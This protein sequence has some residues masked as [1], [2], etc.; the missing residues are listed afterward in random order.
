MTYSGDGPSVTD[1]K[2]RFLLFLGGA[3][4]CSWFTSRR[5]RRVRDARSAVDDLRPDATV[6][7]RNPI[8]D[9]ETILDRPRTWTESGL[10][11][12]FRNR[13]D[14]RQRPRGRT[15]ASTS[16]E[17]RPVELEPHRN[18]GR[19]VDTPDEAK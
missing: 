3:I 13:L 6:A 4:G 1:S 7:A 5:R 8:V 9:G 18:L 14:P 15:T 12:T 19:T 17:L 10:D 11:D 2:Q 16:H